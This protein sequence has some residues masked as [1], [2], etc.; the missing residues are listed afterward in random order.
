L[1]RVI[2]A[3]KEIQTGKDRHLIVKTREGGNKTGTRVL[4][5][6]MTDFSIASHWH[7][8]ATPAVPQ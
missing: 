4:N 5:F 3:V 6:S 7:G 2:K 8:K 1:S